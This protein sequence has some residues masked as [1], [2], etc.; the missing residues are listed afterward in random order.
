MQQSKPFYPFFTVIF[1]KIKILPIK[2]AFHL[3]IIIGYTLGGIRMFKRAYI[4]VIKNKGRT[5]IIAVLLFVIANL[6]LASISI[7][8]AT[9][10]AMDQA[11]ISL[12]P[13]ITL[14][15]DR[16]ALFDFIKEYRDTYGT[17]PSQDI[18]DGMLVPITSDIAYG[19]AE[20]EYVIDY[21]FS[22]TTSS[23]AV[24]F[25]PLTT[26]GELDLLNET[27]ISVIGTYNPLLLD[28]YEEN[29]TYELTAD[30]SSFTGASTNE[31]IISDTLAYENNLSIG[32]TIS[33]EKEDLTSIDFTIVG[34]F[35]N[36]AEIVNVG[37]NI[38]DNEVYIPLNDA[39]ILTGQDPETTFTVTTA[40]YYLDDPLNI[41]IFV[42]ES[43]AAYDE[44][45]DGG[46]TFSDVNYDAVIAPLESVAQ[47]SDIVLIT[48]VIASVIILTLLIVNALKERKYEIGVL[49]SLGE[50]KIKI[51]LQYLFELLLI[52]VIVFTLS[53][54]TSNTVSSY[55]G[56]MLL[57]NEINDAESDTTTDSPRGG[58]MGSITTTVPL[59]VEYIDE[60]DVSITLNDFLITLG[61]GSAIIVL[62]SVIPSFYIMRFQPKKILSSRN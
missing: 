50:E 33:L 58:G 14:T 62:S 22:F 37:K 30:S 41:D 13:E 12:G 43:E 35:L 17:K 49:M 56:A 39:L 18:I 40:K 19:L 15:T 6:V 3:L 21:N 7:K 31:I 29:G 48:V 4:S 23:K 16:T 25:L 28:Q 9:E 36:E 2:T 11:R 32:D 26:E 61:I 57:E 10:E 44:I 51:S 42:S 45:S 8:T 1:K 38:T 53:I 54:A 55:L 52:S 46:L 47:F 60:I 24:D 27:K 5:I 59:D 34:L 20:S